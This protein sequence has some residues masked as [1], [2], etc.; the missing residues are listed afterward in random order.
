M[1]AFLLRKDQQKQ[2]AD[3]LFA[4]SRYWQ[5]SLHFHKGL[6]GA[7]A[8]AIAAARDTAMN[9]AVL[10]AFALAI[11]GGEEPPAFPGIPGHEPDLIAAGKDAAEIDKSMNEL[12][13]I[14]PDA[15]SYV[16][17]SNYF[18]PSWQQ[19]FWGSNYP[20][21]Q[22]VKKKYDPDGLFFVHHG[23][24]SEEWSPDGLTRLTSH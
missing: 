20:R 9:P 4:S 1:P 2:L 15:G 17:E 8:D 21:L 3:A 13:K 11:I 12:R 22:G 19:S 10:D 24:G 6:T 23:V 7:P 14:A 18:E 5:V 16:S